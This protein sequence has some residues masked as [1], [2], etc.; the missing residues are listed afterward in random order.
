MPSLQA[1]AL[2]QVLFGDSFENK[3]PGG[4][5]PFIEDVVVG[6]LPNN[7][8]KYEVWFNLTSLRYQM[9]ADAGIDKLAAYAE[10]VS[11][12]AD[13]RLKDTSFMLIVQRMVDEAIL[14]WR[15]EQRGLEPSEV[16]LDVSLLPF[17][18]QQDPNEQN[19]GQRIGP[20]FYNLAF[21]VPAIVLI[22]RVV[23]EKERHVTGA[24]RSTGLL[25]SAYWTSYW[26]QV[27]FG[28]GWVV[29]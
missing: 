23:R 24:M 3:P 10:S 7:T 8:V 14:V 28:P 5:T 2:S 29:R 18:R 4:A 15:A 17:P 25:D 16:S 12:T 21:T 1:A 20:L 22:I 19:V 27:R 9:Y 6:D 26:L 11:S 13:T